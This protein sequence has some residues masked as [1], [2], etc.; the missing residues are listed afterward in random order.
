LLRLVL[1]RKASA[2]MA[3]R[4]EICGAPTASVNLV[5]LSWEASAYRVICAGIGHPMAFAYSVANS[6]L[7]GNS[8]FN[9]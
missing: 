7:D 1:F 9:S 5:A 2:H 8:W 3:T 4:Q 6:W